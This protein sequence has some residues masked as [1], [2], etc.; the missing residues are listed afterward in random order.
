MSDA[1]PIL[2]FHT[3]DDRGLL[4]SFPPQAFRRNMDGLHQRGYRA[5]P[6]LEAA[7]RVRQGRQ[8]PPRS[9]VLTFDDGY[10]S[11][12]REAFPVLQRYEMSATIFV[13]TGEHRPSGPG[14][15]LPSCEHQPMLN[16]GEIREMHH[17]GVEI[18]AHTCTHPDL[19]RLPTEKIQA[20][21]CDSKAIIEDMLGAAV[22]SFAY[23][24][25]RYDRRS[26]EI[27]Q[28]CFQCACSDILGQVT[29]HSCP[30]ALERVDAYYL[31]PDGLFGLM[32]TKWFPMYLSLRRLARGAKRALRARAG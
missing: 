23:P 21:L 29:R 12:Y 11:V 26:Q 20:E 15:R 30:H 8:F 14:Q 25:G 4:I 5:L 6:L 24:Y 27:A 3:L 13:T 17:W 7:E 28:Q 19:T 16:W 10:Q 2:I 22:R 1:I 9:L 32:L 18:G 31:R